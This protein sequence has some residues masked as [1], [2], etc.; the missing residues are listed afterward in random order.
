MTREEFE[1]VVKSYANAAYR[2]RF[3]AVMSAWDAQAAEVERLRAEVEEREADMHARIRSGY[4]RTVADAW[5]AKVAEVEAERDALRTGVPLTADNAARARVVEAGCLWLP[6][7]YHGRFCASHD[8]S[9]TAEV[10]DLIARGAT[11]LAWRK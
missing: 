1:E 9:K 7:I 8:T 4:D 11:V 10:D 5:R 2:F 3:D 6:T